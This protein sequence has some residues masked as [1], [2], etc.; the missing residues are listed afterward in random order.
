MEITHGHTSESK[1]V[2]LPSQVSDLT[3]QQLDNH[4]TSVS[5]GFYRDQPKGL[6]V[7]TVSNLARGR[8]CFVRA[9]TGYGKTRISEM[10][11][12]LF[13]RKV[14]I[15]VLLP[16]DSLGNDQVREKGL[17]GITAINL[18]KMTLNFALVRKIKRGHYSFVY[19]SPEVFL[20]SSLFT[21]LFFSPEFQNMLA[22]IV[23]DEAHMIYLW[24]LVVSKMSK[25]LAIFTRHEDKAVF[26]PGYGCIATRLLATNKVPLLLL[27]A[28]CR[29]I[30]VDAIINNLKLRPSDVTML[31]GELTQPEIRIIQIPMKS[32]LSSCDDLLRIFA[33]EI[34][35]SADGAR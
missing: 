16:L 35:L 2:K 31:E 19:L 25:G 34:K 29:P 23:V 17:V 4:I 14:I 15:L 21:E 30:A 12:K 11:F 18:N 20:N 28:T 3:D 7:Q 9:G 6:Q 22:L 8:T 24:G 33:P 26:R 10:Y 5:V 1:A 27:S 13:E 32:T